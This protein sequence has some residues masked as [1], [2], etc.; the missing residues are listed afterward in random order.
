MEPTR[1]S[2]RSLIGMLAFIFGLTAYAFAVAAI[3]DLIIDWPI[4][5]LAVYYLIMGIIWIWP[6]KRLLR[7]MADG[8]KNR[9]D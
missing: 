7:W 1:P 2:S 9:E 3:G 8:Y 6:V 5:V 4:L